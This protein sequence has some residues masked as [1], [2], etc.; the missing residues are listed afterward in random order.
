MDTEPIK[1]DHTKGVAISTTKKGK[2][3]VQDDHIF[4]YA[5]YHRHAE[6]DG[7]GNIISEG[8]KWEPEP[9]YEE[10]FAEKMTVDE[11]LELLRFINGHL[12][13]IADVLPALDLYTREA[14]A[15]AS[16]KEQSFN[17]LKGELG[18]MKRE[19][20]KYESIKK[21]ASVKAEVAKLEEGIVEDG[22]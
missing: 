13:K 17:K 14:I 22:Q 7:E 19:L 4:S 9:Q 12:I 5:E 1:F 21:L 6:V 11:V 18:S 15:K 2:R 10:D 3:L 16:I 8:G 20:K